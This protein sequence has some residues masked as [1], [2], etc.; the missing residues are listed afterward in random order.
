MGQS[1]ISGSDSAL[2]YD[3][4]LSTDNDHRYLKTEG[5]LISVGN[6][7]EAIAAPIGVMLAVS[8]LRTPY[9]FQTLIAFSAIPAALSLKEPDRKRLGS[10]KTKG[11]MRA[12][13]SYAF[14][15]NRPLKW[16]IIISSIAGTATLS[17]AW[18]VQPLFVHLSLP[19]FLYGILIPVLN[20]T[21]GTVSIY[22]YAFEKKAGFERS[23]AVIAIGIPTMYLAIGWFNALWA[24]SFLLLFYIIRGV[25]TPMLKNHINSVTPSE[26]RATVLSLRSLIIRLAFVILS[27]ILGWYADHSGLPAAMIAAGSLFLILSIFAA[28]RLIRNKTDGPPVSFSPLLHDR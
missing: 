1:F 25:A 16:N 24:L 13:L 26:I 8:S 22:A 12:I 9:F 4:L 6:Y 28:S 27:P 21:T 3:S 20:L 23:L 17:M 2:L 15:Q 18:L 19:L 11:N 10:S 7:A 14:I 5:R